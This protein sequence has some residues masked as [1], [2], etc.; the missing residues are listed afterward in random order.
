MAN[1]F[2]T[3]WQRLT[4]SDG[5]DKAEVDRI[6]ALQKAASARRKEYAAMKE[7]ADLAVDGSLHSA[8]S[9]SRKRMEEADTAHI[10]AL[11]KW[12]NKESRQRSY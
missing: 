10:V 2:K 11:Q 1:Y 12:Q 3:F 7:Q 9:N 6:A 8:L 5:D 4:A